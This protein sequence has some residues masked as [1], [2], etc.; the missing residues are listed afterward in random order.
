MRLRRLAAAAGLLTALVSVAGRVEGQADSQRMTLG[1]MRG[2]G[3][4]LPFAAFDGKNWSTPWPAAVGAG[5][6][7]VAEL[8]VNL[9]AV[10]SEW[11]GKEVP[12]EWRLWPRGDGKAVAFKPLSPALTIVGRARRLGVRTDYP[13]GPLKVLPLEFP[14]PKEG[15]AIGGQATLEPI[16][17]VSRLAPAASSLIERLRVEIDKAENATIGALKSR[18]GWTHPIDRTARA[19]VVPELEAW[20]TGNLVQPG[21]SVSYIEAVKKYPPQPEDK[22][23]GLETFISGWVHV[24]SRDT[25]LKPQLKATVMYCDRDK[26]SYMLPFGQLQ[27]RNRTHWVFQMSGQD[28]EWYAV[29]EL[30]PGRSRYVAEYQAGVILRQ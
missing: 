17:T 10:P 1:V 2:D 19:A 20:Y 4:M 29:A 25:R 23:C 9:A 21:F 8:P 18:A 13:I 22:G 11:W 26:A 28:H 7:G 5:F 14:Y 30:T 12:A 6:G 15:L 16:A 3:V 24:N 27:V